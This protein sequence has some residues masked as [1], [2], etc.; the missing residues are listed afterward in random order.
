M[1]DLKIIIGEK[2]Y[3]S[4]SLR[5]WLAIHHTG[6]QFEEVQ[7]PLDT[8][9]FY[10]KI[11]TLNPSGRVPALYDGDILVWDSA[12]IIDYCAAL[13][14]KKYWWPSD[15]SALAFA[16]S[17]FAEMHS[18]FEQLRTHAPMNMR[19]RWS[20]LCVASGVQADIKRIDTLWTEARTRFGDTGPFLFGEFSAADM[21][22]APVASRFATY[23]VELSSVSAAYVEALFN[24][25]A[26]KEWYD[27]AL[28]EETI[29]RADELAPSA[30]CLGP[31]D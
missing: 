29:V 27:A 3:S 5:G 11:K 20:G 21:M 24:Y 2:N 4:W 1:S 30:T 10:E 19:G 13:A 14:P 12:A 16:R 31:L 22:Y 26:F 6:L 18:G 28:K 23:G 7:L 8:P 17:I 15:K 25:P 9:E